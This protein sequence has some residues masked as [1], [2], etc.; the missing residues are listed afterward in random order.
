[1]QNSMAIFFVIIGGIIL[2]LGDIVLKKWVTTSYD[3]LYV[4]GILLYLISMNF[5]AHSYKYE[6]IAVASMLMVVFNVLTLTAI[7]YFFFSEN[8]TR[9]ELIGIAFGIVSIGF[10]EFGK[11]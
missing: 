8:I 9:Y 2:T 5:L 11:I 7:G 3:T 10:L 6:D 1:M 4:A